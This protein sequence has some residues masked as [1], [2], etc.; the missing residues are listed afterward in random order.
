MPMACLALATRNIAATRVNLRT[1]RHFSGT[2][3][4][5]GHYTRVGCGREILSTPPLRASYC[6]RKALEALQFA[7]TAPSDELKSSFLDLARG[8]RELA[9]HL[10]QHAREAPPSE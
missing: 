6:R 5:S 9:E 8:W 2:A 4:L 7:T 10:D 3:L 1:G